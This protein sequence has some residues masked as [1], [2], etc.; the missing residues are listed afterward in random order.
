M[1]CT[2]ADFA[3]LRTVVFEQSSN[4]LD[5]ARDYLFPSRLKPLLESFGLPSLEDLVEALRRQPPDSPLKR[6]V[7]E[8]MTVNE[9]SFFRD[10]RIFNLIEKQLLP[11]L[12]AKRQSERRLRLWS[13]A[14][15]TGQEAYSLAMLLREHFPQLQQ[16]QVEITGTDISAAVVSR[17]QRGRYQRIEVNRGLPVR[18]LLKYLQPIDDEW[19]V[20]PVL[21]SLCRFSQRNLCKAPFL[22]EMYDIILLRNVMFYFP[23]PV[24]ERL[25]LNLHRVLA[26][27]GFLILGSSEQPCLPGHFQPVLSQNTCFYKPV[28]LE[29]DR[30][31]SLALR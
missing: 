29:S 7:A 15:S 30:T 9:T 26:S 11:A 22:G 16:W 31:P 19:Q 23:A 8:A 1:T 14:C 18:Y 10:W 25:L 13:A 17:A 28:S 21:Q 12:I 2:A 20:A 24:R 4:L 3:L 27:D 6:A 5:P